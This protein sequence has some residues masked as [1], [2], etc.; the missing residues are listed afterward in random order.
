MAA[1]LLFIILRKVISIRL[2]L[3]FPKCYM[4][5]ERWCLN[6]H[7][8]TAVSLWRSSVASE[9]QLVWNAP[10]GTL[11]TRMEF[12]DEKS[13]SNWHRILCKKSN[14]NRIERKT[15]IVTSPIQSICHG[16]KWKTE[17][18]DQNIWNQYCAIA[19]LKALTTSPPITCLEHKGFHNF[20][21]DA[22]E[23]FELVLQITLLLFT[24]FTVHVITI[25]IP[26]HV[27]TASAYELTKD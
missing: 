19:L 10:T 16:R 24:S 18:T 15:R 23:T 5:S 6:M 27:Q 8:V 1:L 11:Q 25:K 2:F 14:R 9:S 3:T 12:P 4:N 20:T 22:K 17:L 26:D 7:C 21:G 13:K